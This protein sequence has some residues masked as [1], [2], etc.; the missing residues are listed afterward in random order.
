MENI[1]QLKFSLER[2]IEALSRNFDLYEFKTYTAKTSDE[3][4]LFTQYITTQ[5]MFGKNYLTEQKLY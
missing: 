1:I 3:T 2:E 4:K 5:T